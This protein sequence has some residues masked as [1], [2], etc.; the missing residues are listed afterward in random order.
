M[1]KDSDSSDDDEMFY[2]DI[3]S[4]YDY[5]EDKNKLISHLSKKWYMDYW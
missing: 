3:K 5:E 1:A 4:E 2:I